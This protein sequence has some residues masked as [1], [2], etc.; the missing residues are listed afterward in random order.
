MPLAR[1]GDTLLF[2]VH[3]PKTGGTSIETYLRAK[4]S[5]ALAGSRR[6]WSKISLQHLHRTLYEELVPRDFYSRAFAVIREPKARLMSEFRMRATPF[7]AKFR[8]LGLLQAAR[9]RAQGR[10]V[11]AVRV[12][13]RIEYLDFDGW[14]RRVFREYRRDPFF[15]DNHIRPQNEFVEPGQRL[16]LFEEGLEPVFRWI[17][18]ETG[19]P[20]VPGSF[21]ARRSEPIPLTC[22]EHTDAMIRDF[23][24]E[25][26]RLIAEIGGVRT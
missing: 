20:A 9:L 7:R 2:F 15:K 11:Y 6:G 16:F 17:D 5:V 19:T 10:P 1:I 13:G 25:D 14:V 4:G 26:F 24:R 3:I 12:R 8:P 22:S 18:T 23:Y 21:H